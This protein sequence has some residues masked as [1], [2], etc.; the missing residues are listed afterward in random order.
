MSLLEINAKDAEAKLQVATK[1]HLVIICI[2]FGGI[3]FFLY[4]KV[5][6]GQKKFEDYIVHPTHHPLHSKAQTA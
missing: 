1:F 3:S 5:E 4:N 2:V 6:S